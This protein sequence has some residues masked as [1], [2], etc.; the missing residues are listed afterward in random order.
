M[1]H[2][3]ATDPTAPMRVMKILSAALVR[4]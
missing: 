1:Q 4:A 3:D 2:H